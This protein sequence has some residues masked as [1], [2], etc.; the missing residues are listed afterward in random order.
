[1]NASVIVWDL[2]TVPD[3]RGFA[4]VNGLAGKTDEEVREAIGDK[5]PKHIYHSIVCIGALVAHRED[6][7]WA[8]D[9]LGALT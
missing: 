7:H 4:A 1:M 5:F 3:L 8:V 2:E 6:D 9:A